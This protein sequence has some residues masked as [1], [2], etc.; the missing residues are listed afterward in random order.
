[1]GVA[2]W[3]GHDEAEVKELGL[4][5]SFKDLARDPIE[6]VGPKADSQKDLVETDEYEG[7]A[8]QEPRCLKCYSADVICRE[9]DKQLSPHGAWLSDPAIFH[10]KIWRCESC[11]YEWNDDDNA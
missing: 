4:S 1:M 10:E 8:N 11:G 6:A 3:L 7:P 5:L 9:L 2:H